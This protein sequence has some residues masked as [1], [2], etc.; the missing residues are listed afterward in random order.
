MGTLQFQSFTGWESC[1]SSLLDGDPT[2]FYKAWRK[3]CVHLRFVVGLYMINELGKGT[4]C[5][6]EE[7]Q[8]LDEVL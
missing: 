8:V 6:K 7:F 2:A 4:S 3:Y 5:G 1:N